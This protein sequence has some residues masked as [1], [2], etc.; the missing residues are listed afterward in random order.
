[1]IPQL[2]FLLGLLVLAVLALRA[3]RT[4]NAVITSTVQAG[5]A[6][7][8]LED[9]LAR[10]E[11]LAAEGHD[12]FFVTAAEQDGERFVQVS[13]G[14]DGGGVLRY[15]FSIPV[16]DWSRAHAVRIE[17]EAR[18][19][20]LCPVRQD[21][22]AMR[23]LDVEF[24]TSGDHAVFTRWIVKDVYRLAPDSRFDITWS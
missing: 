7:G 14:R 4:A 3:T 23:F 6:Q 11:A 8:T 21:A 2:I 19:R 13:A 10:I 20:G 5:A 18:H 9:Y 1:M 24:D 16:T 15:Q 12:A 22:G 17:A